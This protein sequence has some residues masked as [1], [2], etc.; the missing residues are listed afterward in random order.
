MRNWKLI[1]CHWD[2]ASRHDDVFWDNSALFWRLDRQQVQC[3]GHL[4]FNS[5]FKNC[6]E[7]RT[8]APTDGREQLVSAWSRFSSSPVEMCCVLQSRMW[9]VGKWGCSDPWALIGLLYATLQSNQYLLNYHAPNISFTL[10]SL[11]KSE[12]GRGKVTNGWR[13]MKMKERHSPLSF[14]PNSL[15]RSL[16]RTKAE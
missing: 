11:C 3:V 12:E 15:M 8:Y 4:L 14:C 10:W 7:C 16:L 2:Q 13:R 5:W 1:C 9:I 6:L